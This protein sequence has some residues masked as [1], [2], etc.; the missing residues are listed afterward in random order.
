MRAIVG[1]TAGLSLRGKMAVR[2]IVAAGAF[3]RQ[4]STMAFRPRV[5]SATLAVV[6]GLPADVVGAGQ[7]HD[8]LRVD[9][10]ELAVLQAPEDVLRPVGAPAEV[11]GV[12][13]VEGPRSSGPGSPGSRGRP[14]GA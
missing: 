9:A 11:A 8:D 2:M 6:A 10:V 5:T 4:A 1:I 14:S 3:F 12:P 7:D 13:A